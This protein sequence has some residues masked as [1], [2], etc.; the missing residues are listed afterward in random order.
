MK[1]Y[2]GNIEYRRMDNRNIL[3]FTI[4]GAFPPER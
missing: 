2:A 1:R 3:T 4:A